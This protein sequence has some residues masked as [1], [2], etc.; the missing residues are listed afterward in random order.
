VTVIGAPASAALFFATP[1][2]CSIQTVN[3]RNFLTAVG[4]GGR[5][6]DVV[7]TDAIVV[8]SWELF[9]FNC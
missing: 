8:R 2:T 5:T 3:T 6:T 9:L 1:A 7:H 4:G